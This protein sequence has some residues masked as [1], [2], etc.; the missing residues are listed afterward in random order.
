MNSPVNLV[1]GVSV[2][3]AFNATICTAADEPPFLEPPQYVGPPKALQ[4]VANRAFQ[5]IP[6]I[7]VTPSG[8]LW[9]T[10]YAGKTPSEDQNNYVVLTTSGDDGK[11]WKEV[12]VIDPDEGGPVRA[13]DPE[14]WMGP[15]GVLRAVWA[16]AIGHHGSVAGVWFL[17]ITNPESAQ[18]T[19]A[20]PRRI[21]D[22][23]MM[24]KPLV[25]SSGE[26]VLP[27][28]TWRD[29]DNSAR[30]IVSVDE[31]K[32][33]T[34]RGGCNVPRADRAFDEHMFIERKD[35]SLWLLARTRYGIGESVSTDRGKSWPDLAPSAIAHPSARFFIRRLR[36]GNL[37]LVKHGPIGK[38]TGRSHLTAFVSTNEGKTWDGG[39]LIDER[40]SVSYPDGQQT[41][42]GLIRVIYD[43][44]RT[45]DRHILLA[46][47]R[48]EDAAAGNDVSGSV[49]LRQLVSD[50]RGGEEKKKAPPQPVRANKA[51]S[52]LRT[53]PAGR[54][55][56][57]GKEA[58]PFAV[59]EQLFTDRQY[60]LA[61]CPD[62]FEGATFLRIG[63]DGRKVVRCVQAGMVHFLTPEPDRNRDTQSQSLQDQ[64]FE[65]VAVPEVRLFDPGRTAN[66]CTL[67]Q[68]SC[69]EG[70]TIRFGKW[71]V[72][73]SFP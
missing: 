20:P 8:R 58:K 16:Q 12:L 32:T 72:P 49:K 26:W 1:F 3:A 57:D 67:Y 53:A 65:K 7:A 46:N 68:K 63:I 9:A 70:E 61:E 45:G 64:G 21:T 13:Y 10:W 11:T 38:R 28:S 71:A 50:A 37:L 43:Y 59:G 73:V 22:G 2:L 60:V 30:M 66:Y 44:S 14:L 40:R 25:L 6:S 39:L 4:S 42:D 48:E 27:A 41:A 18:P 36:S 31:G 35:G 55:S 47:F 23:I 62:L 34:I 29:T 5:G 24:C 54:L 17:E 51:G 56:A 19:Y 52:P 69:K 33:W 15:D